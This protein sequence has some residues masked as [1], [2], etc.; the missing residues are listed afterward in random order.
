M[1][2]VELEL[3]LKGTRVSADGRNSVYVC[4]WGTHQGE[5]QKLVCQ[6]I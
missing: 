2:E 1:E 3:A 4:V 6:T 5:Q